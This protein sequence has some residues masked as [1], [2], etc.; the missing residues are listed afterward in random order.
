[1]FV[2]GDEATVENILN[3]Q[4]EH[5]ISANSPSPTAQSKQL[6]DH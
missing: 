5:E 2:R 1:M 3:G 4:S 6:L